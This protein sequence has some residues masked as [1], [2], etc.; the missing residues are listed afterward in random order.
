VSFFLTRNGQ[1][2]QC[3]G[4]PWFDIETCGSPFYY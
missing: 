2:E 1:Q 3:C 4:Y